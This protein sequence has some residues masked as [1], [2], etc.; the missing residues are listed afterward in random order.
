MSLLL[1]F[2]T[3]TET[4]S[5]ALLEHQHVLAV[6][7]MTRSG[8]FGGHSEH[9]LL[10]VT[11]VLSDTGHELSACDAIA[12]G[13][14]PGAFTGLRV[15]CAVAQGL[16]LGIGCPLLAVDCLSAVGLSAIEQLG[17][18][19]ATAGAATRV[20]V[21][22]DARMG[23]IYAELLDIGPGRV[24]VELGP[25]L[26]TPAQA[27][28]AFG[29]PDVVCGSAVALHA[30]LANL[31]PIVSDVSHP[32]AGAIAR[33]GALMLNDGRATDAAAAAP[34]YVRD[35]VALTIAQRAAGH[36]MPA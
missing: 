29:A 32:G 9:V 22:Q 18:E 6:R 2:D 14:G 35:Q 25:L 11:Q 7:E 36:R 24:T 19:T 23:E 10:L 15:A 12:F 20:L 3:S 5:V 31:A 26:V 30:P 21:L 8:G 34:I 4:C 27:F 17:R 1:A 33:I 28:L 16:A 13:A